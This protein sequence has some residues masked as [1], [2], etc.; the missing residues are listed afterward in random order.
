MR[1]F[2]ISLNAS[3]RDRPNSKWGPVE[4]SERMGFVLCESRFRFFTAHLNPLSSYDLFFARKLAM[5]SNAFGLAM[6]C[7]RFISQAIS[8]AKEIVGA[9]KEA[10]A[11]ILQYCSV[12]LFDRAIS[13]PHVQAASWSSE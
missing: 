4:P 10:R 2:Q 5:P 11:A 12:I 7:S 8:A 3:R 1:L 9:S 6:P 13:F